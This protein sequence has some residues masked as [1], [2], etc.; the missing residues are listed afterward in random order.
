[1]DWKNNINSVVFQ[2]AIASF[3]FYSALI[4]SPADVLD[5]A[6]ITLA[7]YTLN[8]IHPGVLLRGGSSTNLAED[9]EKL[10]KTSTITL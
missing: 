10:P 9:E 3:R 8:F 4:I 2:C 5:G 7:I 1:M 6:M